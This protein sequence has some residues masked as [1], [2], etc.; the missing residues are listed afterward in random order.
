MQ[1]QNATPPRWNVANIYPSLESAELRTSIT[2]IEKLTQALET[3]INS[4]VVSADSSI[5]AIATF[6]NGFIAK[7]NELLTLYNTVG[8]YIR[9]FITTDSY[10]VVAKKL[11]SQVEMLGLPLRQ[12]DVR[13]RGILKQTAQHLPA[14]IAEGGEAQ[15]HAFYLLETAQNSQYMMSDAEEALASE[16]GLCGAM[17]WNKLQGT[18][19]S[20]LSVQFERNGK[21][22]TLSMPALINLSH[23]PNP[24]VRR[25][26]YE[27]EHAAWETVKE[28]LGACINGVKGSSITLN[29]KRKRPDHLHEALEQARIDRP[30]LDAMIGAMQDSFP[31]FRRYFR[32]KANFLGHTQG[33][34]WWDVFAPIGKNDR[35]YTWDECKTMIGTQFAQFS[36]RLAQLTQRAFNENW[37]DAEQRTGKR[38]GAFCMG[39]K[40][41]KESRIL[42]NFDGSLDQISTVAHELGHAFHNECL[43]AKSPL[44]SI[45]PMTL[46]E[47]ASIFCETIVT[48]AAL[49]QAQNKDEQIAIL[50]TD[51]IGKAQV[52]V[53]ITSRYIFENELFERR[54]KSEVTA[55]ELCDMMLR[56]QSATYGDGLDERYRHKFM[57]TWKPHYYYPSL[58]FYNFPYAFGLLF[59]TGLYAIY[60]ARG[61]SFVAEYEQLLANTGEGNAADLAARFHIDIRSKAFWQNSLEVIVQRINRYV[62]LIGTE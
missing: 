42:C 62:T 30:T 41:V 6:I 38:G 46:A 18:V 31:A 36:P 53:D 51:L 33:L 60:Q 47:T 25:R 49:A 11:M 37:I 55:D 52:I 7:S 20:Q 15:A 56:A 32:A 61:E 43:N 9:T 39:I 26:A 12:C 57:W 17:A 27:A 58:S 19:T 2:Q 16:L 24:E 21:I 8:A 3:F 29:R 45:T 28:T 34:P 13:F 35:H 23:D 22:E 50:E 59:A 14:V 1:N 5:I 40:G 10:N 54:A 44:Q 48:E 4:H